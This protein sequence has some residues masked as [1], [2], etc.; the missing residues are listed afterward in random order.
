[1]TTGPRLLLGLNANVQVRG[2]SMEGLCVH[3]SYR[4]KGSALRLYVGWTFYSL[5]DQSPVKRS[6]NTKSEA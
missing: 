2:V 6:R 5:F 4:Q 1:M 3:M